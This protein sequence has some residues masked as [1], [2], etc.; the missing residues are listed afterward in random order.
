MSN[1]KVVFENKDFKVE[2]H[3][4]YIKIVDSVSTKARIIRLLLDYSF[5]KELL[6][7]HKS[8]NIVYIEKRNP[9]KDKLLSVYAEEIAE[10]IKTVDGFLDSGVSIVDV[11]KFYNENKKNKVMK[12]DLQDGEIGL[13]IKEGDIY[14]LLL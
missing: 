14:I 11:I 3:N 7:T 10:F 12:I 5:K 4:S 13:C 8:F 1:I 9:N 6:L 2:K